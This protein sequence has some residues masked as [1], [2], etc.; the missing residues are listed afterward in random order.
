[1][2]LPRSGNYGERVAGTW[3]WSSLVL[4]SVSGRAGRD[5]RDFLV[6]VEWR[7]RRQGPFECRGA[8]APWVGFGALAVTEGVIDD[9]DEPERRREGD[10][11][12]NGRDH[13]PSGEGLWIF[14][15]PPR[16]DGKPED[17]LRE[18]GH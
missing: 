11:G 17:M 9:E 5:A 10:E 4:P 15:D 8:R 13:V 18:R 3:L 14:V 6:G 1:M 7:R 2:R 12:P 16:H